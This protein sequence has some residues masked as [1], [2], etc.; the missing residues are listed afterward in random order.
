MIYLNYA[1]ID[2]IHGQWYHKLQ[3]QIKNYFSFVYILSIMQ[4]EKT[5]IF[6]FSAKK[7]KD[8]VN[9]NLTKI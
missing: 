6:I 1:T 9:Y 2:T 8:S 3:K 5:N 7:R 4:Y